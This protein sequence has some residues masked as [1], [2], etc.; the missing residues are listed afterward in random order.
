MEVFDECVVCLENNLGEEIVVGKIKSYNG[1]RCSC[2][3]T[4]VCKSCFEEMDKIAKDAGKNYSCPICRSIPPNDY[5]ELFS[6]YSAKAKEGKSWA[7]EG[8]NFIVHF[9]DVIR[10][11][12][13]Y[14]LA[15]GNAYYYGQGIALNYKKALEFYSLAGEQGNSNALNC[16][17]SMYARGI[18]IFYFNIYSF[19]LVHII[20]FIGFSNSFSLYIRPR[21]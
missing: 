14:I 4:L 13:I 8:K 1:N 10:I 20:F 19:L 17:G 18:I 15:V 7:Q 3:G 12:N 6:L 9:R 21:S 11:I 16:I 2:C 5:K